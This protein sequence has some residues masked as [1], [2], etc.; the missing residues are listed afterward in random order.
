MYM[1]PSSINKIFYLFCLTSI[2]IP[3]L[4]NLGTLYF[5]ATFI[6]RDTFMNKILTLS[7]I[8]YCWYV[9]ILPNLSFHR[10]KGNSNLNRSI[11]WKCEFKEEIG[12]GPGATA[13]KCACSASRRPRVRWFGSQVQTWHRVASHAGVGVP[14]I[15]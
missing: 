6:N 7:K 10:Y 4:D 5:N 3:I 14:H 15:K 2:S 9:G 8:S 12:A 1:I 13:V 11:G